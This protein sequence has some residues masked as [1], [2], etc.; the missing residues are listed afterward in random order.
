MDHL[1]GL[2]FVDRVESGKDLFSEEEW[3]KQFIDA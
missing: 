2:T 3:R 1:D